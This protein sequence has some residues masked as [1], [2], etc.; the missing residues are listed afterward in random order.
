MASSLGPHVLLNNLRW[1]NHI[2]LA[3]L[4]KASGVPAA[5]ISQFEKGLPCFTEAD[6]YNILRGLY[7][8]KEKLSFSYEYF[9]G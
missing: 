3:M 4:A 1:S 9:F 8:I 7:K 5:R 2:T 6:K